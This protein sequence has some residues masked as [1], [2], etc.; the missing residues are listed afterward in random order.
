MNK[1]TI[2]G[3]VIRAIEKC[4]KENVFPVFIIPEIV[5]EKSRDGR[6]GDYATSIALRLAK[7]IKQSSLGIA[8]KI[9]SILEGLNSGYFSKIEIAGPGFINFFLSD[10]YLRKQ[11]RE[12]IKK[13]EKYGEVNIGKKKKV[14]VEHTSVNPNKAMHIGNLRNAILGDSIGR[15]LRKVG[16]SV[17]IENYID[18]TGS[19]VADTVTAILYLNKKPKNKQMFDDFCWDIYAEINRLYETEPQLLEKKKEVIKKIEEGNNKTADLT[20][21]VSNKVLQCHLQRLAEFGIFYDLLVYESDVIRS[22]FWEKAFKQLKNNPRF[23]LETQ[24]EQKG[25]WILKYEGSGGNKIFVRNDG[26]K[27]YTAKDTAYH[28]WKFGLLKKDFL[29]KRWSWKIGNKKIWKTSQGGIHKNNFGRADKIIN[30][31]DERQS[32][33]QEMVKLALKSLGFEKEADNYHHLAYGVVYLSPLTAKELK[34]DISDNKPFY[35]MAGRKGIGIKISDLVELLTKNIKEKERDRTEEITKDKEFATSLE[36]AVGAIRHYIL[37]YNYRSQ[38]IFDYD[39]ALS[40]NGNTGPYLQYSHV[41]AAGILRKAGKF[42]YQFDKKEDLSPSERG[43][44]KSLSRWPEIVEET[45]RDFAISR[46]TDYAFELSSCF[47]LFYEKNPVIKAKGIV[48]DFRL[49][50]VFAYQKIISDVL[51]VMGISSPKRM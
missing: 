46:I 2:V 33:P 51:S 21:E 32:Y 11:V 12:I 3:L 36:I 40:L 37:K 23:I 31:I 16:Y 29:Y 30:V 15:L 50:L 38:V 13:G 4:Q 44:I 49:T 26:T 18:D 22:G 45:G 27:I 41:R 19:Q 7:D 28:L 24:G 39:Q 20:E 5:V 42:K 6:Y 17:E 10:N 34:I 48:K 47:H 9:K 14:I 8:E 43:M 35:A 25:C 1:Q